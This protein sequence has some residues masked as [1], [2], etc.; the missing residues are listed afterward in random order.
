MK[1][2]MIGLLLLCVSSVLVYSQPSSLR[3]VVNATATRSYS[4]GAI[5]EVVGW[6][7][8]E[9]QGNQPFLVEEGQISIFPEFIFSNLDAQ[10]PRI[11]IIVRDEKGYEREGTRIWRSDEAVVFVWDGAVNEFF[12]TSVDLKHNKAA[13]TSVSSGRNATAAATAITA[14]CY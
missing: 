11:R 14:D 13:V 7:W 2:A 4:T 8:R 12:L 10:Q 1:C 5:D 3:C 6:R 9:G